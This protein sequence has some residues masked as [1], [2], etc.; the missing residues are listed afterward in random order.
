MKQKITD[1]L[2]IC[3]KTANVLKEN[4]PNEVMKIKDDTVIPFSKQNSRKI[5]SKSMGG[6]YA[7]YTC[8]KPHRVIVQQK[9]LA[10]KKCFG[11]KINDQSKRNMLYGNFA[12]VELMC[13]EL[14]HHR[15]KGHGK[16]FK[17]KYLRFLGF[18]V[19]Q[20]LSGKFYQNHT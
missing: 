17:I 16:K 15:T 6:C 18:M 5:K 14:A 3:F 2:E 10:E 19:S 4:F 8:S 20:I 13:H 11:T 12:L 9:V 7:C 1:G